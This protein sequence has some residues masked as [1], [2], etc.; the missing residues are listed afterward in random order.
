MNKN[1][2]SLAVSLLAAVLLSIILALV[3][4]LIATIFAFPGSVNVPVNL[5][6]KLVSL[7]LGCF[8]FVKEE[9]GALLGLL[10]G[11]IYFFVSSCFFNLISGDWGISLFTLV[12][13]FYCAIVGMI[14][15]IIR[16]NI[17]LK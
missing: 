9:K 11:V 10:F 16:I 4:S 13:I 7:L 6:I 3:Y 1:I 2:I 15:G 5:V 8:M 17:S 12:N 14:A